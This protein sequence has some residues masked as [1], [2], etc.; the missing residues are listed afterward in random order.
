MDELS[1]FIHEELF[2]IDTTETR[3]V[4]PEVTDTYPLAVI[5]IDISE[6]ETIL[7]ESILSALKLGVSDVLLTTT[8]V[9]KS[10]NRW[11]IFAESFQL[12]SMRLV[13][14]QPCKVQDSTLVL[15]QPLS[16]LDNSQEEK[17]KLWKALKILFNI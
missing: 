13:F 3:C 7:L 11:V 6:K 10:S 14:Y 9:S 17:Q 1:S 5:A 16:V 12:Q 4:D 2:L 15:A 8:F